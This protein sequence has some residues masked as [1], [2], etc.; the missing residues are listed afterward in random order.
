MRVWQIF[1][2][3]QEVLQN[4]GAA[5][6]ATGARRPLGQNRRC[7]LYQSCFSLAVLFPPSRAVPAC[8]GTSRCRATIAMRGRV[9]DFNRFRFR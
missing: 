4:F 7:Y 3:N 9:S 1:A 6:E 2:L 8:P 5:L